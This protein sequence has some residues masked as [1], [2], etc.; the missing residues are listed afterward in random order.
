MPE[1]GL[2]APQDGSLGAWVADWPCKNLAG[3]AKIL[4]FRTALRFDPKYDKRDYRKRPAG[5]RRRSAVRGDSGRSSFPL[6]VRS[7]PI[8]V[9]SA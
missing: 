8:A 6:L 1:T 2:E 3:R 4:D 5:V 7:A 9:L